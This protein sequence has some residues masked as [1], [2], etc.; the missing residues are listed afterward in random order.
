MKFTLTMQEETDNKIVMISKDNIEFMED[1]LYLLQ[2]F[3]NAIGY[4]YIK[5]IYAV[6]DNGKEFSHTF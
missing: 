3:T 1:Y 2:E 6:A 4:D 5:T